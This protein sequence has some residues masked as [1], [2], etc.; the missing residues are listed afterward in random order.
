MEFLENLQ[1]LVLPKGYELTDKMY[2]LPNGAKYEIIGVQ[3]LLILTAFEALFEVFKS[4]LYEKFN[5]GHSKYNVPYSV[6]IKFDFWSFSELNS[7]E[8]NENLLLACLSTFDNINDSLSIKELEVLRE[9]THAPMGIINYDIIDL[10]IA[11]DYDKV[12]HSDFF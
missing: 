4:E 5:M 6:K 11:R 7:I 3:I 10:P 9:Y 1:D 8:E 12:P 2:I